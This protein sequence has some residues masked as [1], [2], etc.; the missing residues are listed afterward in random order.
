MAWF[1][2][3]CLPSNFSTQI[4]RPAGAAELSACCSFFKR[5]KPK[6]LQAVGW[7]SGL[8]LDG[9]VS[10]V[11]TFTTLPV[12]VIKT[13]SFDARTVG[14]V[15]TFSTRNTAAFHPVL[16]FHLFR[17]AWVWH[18]HCLNRMRRTQIGRACAIDRTWKEGIQRLATRLIENGT[19]T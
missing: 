16:K 10:T 8:S 15:S 17:G 7:S 4:A 1:N 5:L 11:S 3:I 19:I 18:P 13:P 6:C 9:E 2:V 12:R 14:S